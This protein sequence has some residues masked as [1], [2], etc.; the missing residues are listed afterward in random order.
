M[1]L[2]IEPLRREH[3]D[4][5]QLRP[6]DAQGL[7]CAGYDEQIQDFGE[8]MLV[9]G[10]AF[11]ALA[12]P[13]ILACAGMQSLRQGVGD[14]WALTSPELPRYGV[15]FCR[16]VRAWLPWVCAQQGVWRAQALVLEQHP[17]SCRWL[18]WL[19]FEREG[20]LRRYFGK[21]N[22]YIYARVQ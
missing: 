16:A 4:R 7:H 9:S 15:A 14:L 11:T 12:G 10:V 13:R 3:L 2:R 22:F 18:E 8:Q 20:L 21:Q 17:V 5:I 19:G 6:L 1:S